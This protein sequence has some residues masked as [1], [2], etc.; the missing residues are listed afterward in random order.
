MKRFTILGLFLMLSSSVP[1]KAE[2]PLHQRWMNFISGQ[3]TY[4]WTSQDGE[5]DE[6]GEVAVKRA[7]DGRARTTSIL[8][9]NGD[10]ESEL[11]GWQG[12]RGVLLV[13]GFSSNGGY[14]HIEYTDLQDDTMSGAGYG[15]LADGKPWKGELTVTRQSGDAYEI[16][17]SGTAG[18][19]PFSTVGQHN[20]MLTPGQA[21]IRK[22]SFLIG[23][24]EN[25][26]SNGATE[27]VSSKWINNNSYML[28]TIGDYTE[29]AGWDLEEKQIVSWGFG[30]HGGQGKYYWT[31]V[32]DKTW[33][34]EA[35]PAFL[36]RNGKPFQS[37]NTF[38]IID[39]DTLKIELGGGDSKTTIMSRRI[40][41]D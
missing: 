37:H 6:A 11:V 40:K 24:W 34:C 35:K 26:K 33:T 18:G 23:E 13:T 21:A 16:R 36:D 12:D 31:Q 17:C 27:R 30:T 7:A 9:E 4:K 1:V 25:T 10:R 28:T 32:D 14:W 5:H 20:R 39:K 15:V 8:T 38:T 3:W 2:E 29:I 22:L 41:K 19:E